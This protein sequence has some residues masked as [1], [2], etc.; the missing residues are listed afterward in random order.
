MEKHC[1]VLIVGA[2]PAGC[3]TAYATAKKGLNTI[4]IEEHDEIGKPIKCAEAIGSY[5]FEYLPFPIP[6]DQLLWKIEGMYFWADGLAFKKTGRIWQG[7]SINRSKW[8]KWLSTKAIN[9]GAKIL[10]NTQLES[11]FY[12]ERKN[13]TTIIAKR[14]NEKI[15]INAK[16][17]VGADGIDS[18]VLKQIHKRS[19]VPVGHV[20]SY[21]MKNLD[22]KYPQYEQI[23]IGEFAPRAYAYIF[24][25]SKT[26]ANIGIG[27][28]Y[29]DKDL[30]DLFDTFLKVPIVKKQTNKGKIVIEKSG[31]A[32]VKDLSERIAYHNVF[33]TG[34]A[35][36]QNIKPF[37]EG[38]LPGII[39]GGI[40]GNFIYE[41]NQGKR[42]TIEYDAE[43]HKQ[44]HIIK[45]SEPY[46]DLVYGESKVDNHIYP[47]LMLSLM[48][49]IIQPTENEMNKYIKKGHSFLKKYILDNG[50][51]IEE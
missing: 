36:N 38:N 6:Q 26:R 18:T 37:I 22:L 42:Q 19:D 17:V 9:Q 28:I 50:G 21:E 34:D 12:D 1:D 48:S 49:E 47:L 31:T 3:A 15:S 32:P 30:D 10:L 35:A 29:K 7:Y 24:P 39:C 33:L 14:G 23:F 51:Y 11:L 43:I 27:T 13:I 45:E 46:A 40:L 41:V 25:L 8:D 20:K 16:Y 4:I 44:F 2:G 5:L